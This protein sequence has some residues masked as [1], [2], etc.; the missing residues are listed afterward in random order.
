MVDEYNA[1]IYNGTLVLVPRPANVNVVHSMWIFKH[2]FNADGSLS[3][4]KARLVVMSMDAR[5]FLSELI[6][7]IV[8]VDTNSKLGSDGDLVS[9]LLAGALHAFCAVVFL[10]MVFS[11]MSGLLL[12]LLQLITYTD[13]LMLIALLPEGRR[14][15][16]V[17]FLVIIFYLGPQSDKLPCLVTFRQEYRDAPNVVAETAWIV[18][19]ELLSPLFTATLVYCHNVRVLYM[20]A[21]LVQHQRTKHIEIDINFVRDFVASGQ[22]RVLHVPSRFQSMDIFTNDLPITL[23]IEFCSGLNVRRPPAQTA[24]EY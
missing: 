4:Y 20:S 8:R 10:I 6:C 24:R 16:I 3:M 7:R 15:G 11:F 13:A 2:K 1:L 5:K 14:P 18:L 9:D 19:C 12:S 21:N 22:V 23:F 17:Y